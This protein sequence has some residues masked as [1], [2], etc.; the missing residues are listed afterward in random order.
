MTSSVWSWVPKAKM[1][2]GVGRSG[3]AG[4]RLFYWY[5]LGRAAVA[6]ARVGYE[7]GVEVVRK[8]FEFLRHTIVA[9]CRRVVASTADSPRPSPALADQRLADRAGYL[10]GVC[11]AG[12]ADGQQ[13]GICLRPC[14]GTPSRMCFRSVHFLSVK[15]CST[16]YR[17]CQ[18]SWRFRTAI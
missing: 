2:L 16:K 18:T 9:V 6:N 11:L 8:A 13:C 17:H 4:L 7:V 15:Y 12:C 3:S 14:Q 5:N 10:V 1:R